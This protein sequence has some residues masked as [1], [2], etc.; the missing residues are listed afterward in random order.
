MD[1]WDITD[2]VVLR[3]NPLTTVWSVPVITIVK[4]ALSMLR[5]TAK[6]SMLA[7]GNVRKGEHRDWQARVY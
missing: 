7:P 5:P 4:R 6:D 3:E 1:A 2:N